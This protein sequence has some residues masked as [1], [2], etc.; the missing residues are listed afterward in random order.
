MAKRHTFTTEYK[1]KVTLEAAKGT[2]TLSELAQEYQ[3]HP[4]QIS[5]W[6][7]HLLKSGA[8]VFGS[9]RDP[10]QHEHIPYLVV[11][12]AATPGLFE[13]SPLQSEE[14]PTRLQ[15]LSAQIQP[16]GRVWL[17]YSVPGILT[18]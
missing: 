3:L 4:H 8:E 6:K 1:F 16:D 12:D 17:R 10:Q 2:K 13:A 7:S 14:F 15:L 9:D 5:E 18:E 11:G